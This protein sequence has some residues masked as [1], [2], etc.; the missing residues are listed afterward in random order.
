[1]HCYV[2]FFQ[3]EWLDWCVCYAIYTLEYLHGDN[4]YKM[5]TFKCLYIF[6]KQSFS[7]KCIIIVTV[8][9]LH[10]ISRWLSGR[11]WQLL[12]WCNGVTSVLLSDLC[13][14]WCN[15]GPSICVPSFIGACGMTDRMFKSGNSWH[16]VV[17]R[18]LPLDLSCE[19]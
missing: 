14:C 11:L 15:S 2:I 10:C 12:C 3:M 7:F 4:M 5:Y 13:V 8:M 9:L 17:W 16:L 19:L 1:M 18:E 6:L